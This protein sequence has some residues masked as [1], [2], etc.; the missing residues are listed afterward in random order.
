MALPDDIQALRDRVLADLDAAHDYYA[1]TKIG[2]DLVRQAIRRYPWRGAV[3][4][5]ESE[6]RRGC[7]VL[8]E[9]HC[10]AFGGHLFGECGLA[11]PWQPAG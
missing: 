8:R 10:A 11:D 5:S 3:A 6:E 2:W 7:Q 9:A 1:D 4:W